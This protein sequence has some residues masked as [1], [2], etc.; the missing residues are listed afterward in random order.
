MRRDVWLYPEDNLLV[1]KYYNVVNGEH[2]NAH[3]GSL[4]RQL[5]NT[6]QII[7]LVDLSEATLFNIDYSEFSELFENFLHRL[8]GVAIKVA[9]YSGGNDKDDFMKASTFTKFEGGHVQIENFVE[10]FDAF[11]W[12]ELDDKLRQKIWPTLH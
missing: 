4:Y 8:E 9:L 10:L 11:N 6:R 12:L 3:D 2:L 5:D 7:S 1:E